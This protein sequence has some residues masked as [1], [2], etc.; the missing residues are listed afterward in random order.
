MYVRLMRLSLTHF[1]ATTHTGQP[2]SSIGNTAVDRDWGLKDSDAF[3]MRY[4][5]LTLDNSSRPSRDGQ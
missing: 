4:S 5:T 3:E 1:R 2:V